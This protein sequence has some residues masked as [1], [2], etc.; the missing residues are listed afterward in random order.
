MDL[1][2]VWLDRVQQ[3]KLIDRMS[4]PQS[5]G[6]GFSLGL[7]G[8]ALY[9]CSSNPATEPGNRYMENMIVYAGMLLSAIAFVAPFAVRRVF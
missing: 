6:K 1:P 2:S 5:K 3:R 8:G 7:R 9:W 4:P